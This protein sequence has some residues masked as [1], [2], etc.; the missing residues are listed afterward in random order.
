M[1]TGKGLIINGWIIM[2]NHV[3]L[4]ARSKPDFQL[5]DTMR[6]LKKFTSK[7]IEEAIRQ[8]A[9]ESR[10]EWMLWM[11]KRAGEKNSNNKYFQFWHQNNHLIELYGYE[12]LKQKLNYLHENYVHAGIA[13]ETWYYKYRSAIDYCTIAHSKIDLEQV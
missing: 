6:D 7:K 9:Y 11:F 1:S 4:I 12:T 5:A 2:S 8:N 10:R 13:Y 3:H